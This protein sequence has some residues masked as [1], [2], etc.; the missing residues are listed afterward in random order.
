MTLEE[1]N[2]KL[3]DYIHKETAV[4]VKFILWLYFVRSNKWLIF[5]IAVIADHRKM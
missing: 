1:E 4:P 2:E 5:G 3:K